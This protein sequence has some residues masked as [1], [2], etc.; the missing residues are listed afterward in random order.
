MNNNGRG[1]FGQPIWTEEDYLQVE[2]ERLR[3]QIEHPEEYKRQQEELEKASE[4][5]RKRIEAAKNLPKNYFDGWEVYEVKNG[6][7]LWNIAKECLGSGVKYT[8]IIKDNDQQ[9]PFK[10]NSVRAGMK[11]RFKK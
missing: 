3:F 2:T 10:E 11:L 6:D 5:I 7:N 9:L 8:E 4:D 1:P